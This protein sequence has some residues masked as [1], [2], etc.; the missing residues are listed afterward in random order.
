MTASA[1]EG[2]GLKVWIDHRARPY[3]CRY[4]F[5]HSARFRGLS[6]SSTSAQ[7]ILYTPPDSKRL[8]FLA[9]R[10]PRGS[11][12]KAGDELAKQD[13]YAI[14]ARGA[15][16]S[17]GLDDVLPLVR[18]LLPCLFV[19]PDD[20]GGQINCAQEV[21]RRI[22]QKNPSTIARQTGELGVPSRRLNG[23]LDSALL[24]LISLREGAR[25]F[26][27]IFSMD[28]ANAGSLRSWSSAGEY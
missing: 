21:Q 10:G 1:H 13:A 6:S 8:R 28:I 23:L 7:I 5:E 4:G 22:G 12:S 24:G 17:M 19:L 20:G 26:V 15:S 27:P 16:D 11:I 25:N 18:T 3:A 9:L 2:D 14:G